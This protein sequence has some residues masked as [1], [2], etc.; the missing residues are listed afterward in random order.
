MTGTNIIILDFYVAFAE[1]EHGLDDAI[2]LSTN[3]DYGLAVC[4][5]LCSMP[6]GRERRNEQV[7]ATITVF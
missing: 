4:P 1:L 2:I 3:I 6:G 5:A 7:T